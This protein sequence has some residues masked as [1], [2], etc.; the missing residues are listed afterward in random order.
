MSTPTKMSEKN[1]SL[2][3]KPVRVKSTKSSSADKCPKNMKRKHEEVD[4]KDSKSEEITKFEEY[5]SVK[6]QPCIQQFMH[7][8]TLGW[9]GQI[10]HNIAMRL[11]SHRGMGDA[12]CFGLGEAV[13][14]FSINEFCLITGLNCVGSTHLPVVES[15]LITRY[16]STL[17]GVSRENLEVQMSNAKF[18]NDDDAV[19]LSL[20]YIIALMGGNTGCNL[21]YCGQQDVFEEKT[22]KKNATVHYSLPGFH[23]ALLVW[24]FET[25]P[26]IATKF[27]TKYEPAIPRM[28]SWTT[29]ENVKFNDVVAAFTTL[30]EDEMV[31]TVMIEWST[32]L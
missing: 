30:D 16:F 23:H 26:S 8:G 27:T 13:G 24:A 7:L 3:K 21:P 10:F 19:K 32:R 31:I 28:T 4:V 25:I 12:L 14:R 29:A 6:Q 18:D 5:E 22:I 1:T 20:Q 15:R 11:M 17:R 2:E 9:A